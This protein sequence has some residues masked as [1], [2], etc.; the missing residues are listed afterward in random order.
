MKRA[1]GFTFA[2]L[3][4][5]LS[6]S[7]QVNGSGTTDYVPIWT[8]NNTLAN[9]TIFE[10]QGMVGIG[11]VT[12]RATLNVVGQNGGVNSNAPIVLQVIGGTGGTGQ[13]PAAGGPIQLTA[14]NGARA[15]V[16][17]APGGTG[18]S[19]GITAGDGGNGFV[20]GG[21]GGP[22]QFASGI[23]GTIASGAT[24][25]LGASIQLTPGTGAKWGSGVSHGGNGGSITLQ[26]GAGGTGTASTG[27]VGKVVLA[28]NGGNVGI[29]MKNP[30]AT[31]ELAV[32]GTTLADQW[33]TRS[34]RRFKTNIQPL[35]GALAK[36]LQLQ[37]VSYDR[38]TDGQHEIGVVAEDVAQ[39]VP[40]VVSR[41]PSTHE[42][43]GVDYSKMSSLL[44]EAIKSQQAEIQ[45]L[46]VLIDQ[47]RSKPSGQ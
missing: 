33:T 23:G 5:V 22:L 41:D 32:G 1:C 44:I 31:F 9:S 36:V 35:V 24:G 29:G 2:L 16:C 27:S 10:V 45:Q 11:T 13:H 19:V 20:N 37:G 40:E 25:G 30:T 21:I 14:G 15:C 18:G 42:V 28:P 38:K 17:N 8:D 7:A 46:K 34:S 39:V 43:Q 3:V 26:P 47:L 12:P 6:A 4:L